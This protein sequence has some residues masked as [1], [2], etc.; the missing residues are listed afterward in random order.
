MYQIG[1]RDANVKLMRIT[2][3]DLISW[4]LSTHDANFK[5]SPT[6]CGSSFYSMWSLDSTS[7]GVPFGNGMT[8]ARS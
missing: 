2:N 1:I 3:F 5:E 6:H 8:A 7:R 4:P